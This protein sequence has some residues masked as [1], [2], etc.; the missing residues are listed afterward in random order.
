MSGND[1]GKS[2]VP[3]RG[4]RNSNGS[5]KGT[6]GKV[7]SLSEIG[8]RLWS[9]SVTGTGNVES[10]RLIAPE[11]MT[12]AAGMDRILHNPDNPVV[13]RVPPVVPTGLS[14][15]S[16]ESSFA[17][18]EV[19]HEN[20]TSVPSRM[21]LVVD[22]RSISTTTKGKMSDTFY[23]TCCDTPRDSLCGGMTWDPPSDDIRRHLQSTRRWSLLVKM[24]SACRERITQ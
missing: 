23:V 12:S 20:K 11:R 9:G 7:E 5:F 15:P 13:S 8:M 14:V 19:T 1:M 16:A 22:T 21:Q 4:K 3:V 10:G 24:D 6:G 18:V 2:K 17:A